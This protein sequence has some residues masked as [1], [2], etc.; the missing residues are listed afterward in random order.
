MDPLSF[1][2]Q[3]CRLGRAAAAEATLLAQFSQ[4]PQPPSA[5]FGLALALCNLEQDQLERAEACLGRV[6]ADHGDSPALLSL[7]IACGRRRGEGS[8]LAQFQGR[9]QP[10]LHQE[11]PALEYLQLLQEALALGPVLAWAE[12]LLQRFPHS[13]AVVEALR[14]LA[15]QLADRALLEAVAATA[16]P[17]ASVT[18]STT[19]STTASAAEDPAALLWAAR[20]QLLGGAAGQALAQLRACLADASAAPAL[21]FQALQTLAQSLP[22]PELLPLLN[23][24]RSLYS[25]SPDWAWSI[26]RQY[27]AAGAWAQGWPLYEQRYA[28]SDRAQILPPGFPLR[29]LEQL[30]QPR[31]LENRHVL[32]YGEQGIGDMLMFGSLLPELLAEAA[33]VRLLLPPRLVELFQSSFPT[34]LVASSF[35]GPE[36]EQVQLAF[37]LGSLGGV[38]RPRASAFQGRG[39][40]L[41]LEPSALLTWRQRLAGLGPGARIGIAWRGGGSLGSRVQ[42]SLELEQLLPILQ[43]PGVQWLNLQYGLDPAELEQFERRHGIRLHHFEGVG[44]NLTATAALT[45]ALDLVITV[46]QTAL[47]IAA[48]LGV[49]AWVLV[50][51]LAEWRYGLEG[52]SMPWYQS[53]ELF[54]QQERGVWQ[55]VIEAMAERLGVWLVGHNGAINFSGPW[56]EPD[57]DGDRP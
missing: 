43:L 21:R 19:A 5:S 15:W 37:S 51:A 28:S 44:E 24:H 12:T 13:A 54:R 6:A 31:A 18:A 22:A 1:A 25:N 29:G 17:H 53:V 7:A 3:Q 52:P 56:P 38:Y 47:H 34:A 23:S 39:P 10:F 45:A 4:Q 8:C 20:L 57:S 11:G 36:L 49:P 50:P 42:R 30:Q 9:L 33:S 55:S 32:L 27:L 16:S 26:G 14:S 35:D 41:R 48:G 40:H 2:Q 46:Q